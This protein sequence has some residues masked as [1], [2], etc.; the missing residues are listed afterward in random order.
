MS[1]RIIRGDIESVVAPI[2]LARRRTATA[3]ARRKRPA[4]R[5]ISGRED[6]AD[7]RR[8]HARMLAQQSG[9]AYQEASKRAR[10][11][12]SASTTPLRCSRWSSASAEMLAVL[13]RACGRRIRRESEEELVELSIAIARRIL[14]RELTLDPEA[15]RGL[16]K[17]AL[18]RIGS[19]ELSRVR[20][21][22]AHGAL[23]AAAGGT[24]PV[25]IGSVELVTDPALQPRRHGVRNRAR[26]SRRFGGLATGRDPARPGGS[27][28]G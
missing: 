8:R 11:R 22:P 21:H 3:V 4:R 23:T 18:D 27:A 6:E 28:G 25:R 24:R 2:R 12:C 17:A 5:R 26:R 14:H 13:R 7:G 15:V 9:K 1:S 20:V 19:R 16:V 10:P